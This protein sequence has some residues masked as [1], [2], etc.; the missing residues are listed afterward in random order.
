M[1]RRATAVALVFS[2]LLRG[3]RH[4]PGRATMRRVD[5]GAA[6]HQVISGECQILDDWRRAAEGVAQILAVAIEKRQLR[7][8]AARRCRTKERD[9]NDQSGGRHYCWVADTVTELFLPQ[10]AGATPLGPTTTLLPLIEKSPVSPAPAT[11]IVFVSP[12][13]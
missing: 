12:P 4:N 1:R 13:A 11:L 6:D 3:D 8:G 10:L 7:H 9:G 2:W 5:P